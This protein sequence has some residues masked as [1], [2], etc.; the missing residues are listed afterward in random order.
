MRA[1]RGSR[2]RR[3]RPVIVAA[4]PAA[5]RFWLADRA[6]LTDRLVALCPG[7]FQL[8]LLR[9]H[10]ARPLRDEAAALGLARGAPALVREVLLACGDRPWVYARTVIPR[11]TLTGPRR[12]L[13]R[14]R[15]RSLGSVLFSDP[16]MRRG[17][18]SVL[19]LKPAMPLHTR[20]HTVTARSLPVLWGRRAVFRLGARPL[21]VSEFFLPELPAWPR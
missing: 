2:W 21:L 4:A 13:A 18:S 17:P 1:A 8:R 3:A 15:T 19:Q 12:R 14:L 20:I 16:T 6:S 9:Q 5:L 11:A 10:Y 7:R